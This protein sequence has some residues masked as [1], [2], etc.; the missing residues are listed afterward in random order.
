[1]NT[2]PMPKRLLLPPLIALLIGA[3]HAGAEDLYRWKDK[4]GTIHYGERSQAPAESKKIEAANADDNLAQCAAYARAMVDNTDKR[5][6]VANADKIKA[7]CPGKGFECTTVY[8][9]PEQNKCEP[10][11]LTDSRTFFKDKK[12]GFP[13]K[14]GNPP[15]KFF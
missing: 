11:P 6:W 7:A 5:D 4:N 2:L 12:I 10:F 9:H 8:R 14:R 1:M 15:P 13:A 3:T